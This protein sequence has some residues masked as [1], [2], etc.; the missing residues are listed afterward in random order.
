M[1]INYHRI[2]IKLYIPGLF[3]SNNELFHHDLILPLEERE[4]FLL[5]K[6]RISQFPD[7]WC[8]V[9]V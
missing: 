8:L 9:F 1:D 4:I 2:Y 7:V 3:Y 6:I 5:F